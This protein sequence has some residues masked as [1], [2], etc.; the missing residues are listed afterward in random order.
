MKRLY[1]LIGILCLFAMSACAPLNPVIM[2]KHDSFDSYKYVYITPTG[3]VT[4]NAG[5]KYGTQDNNRP[6][7]QSINP[8]DFIA[9][10]L[11]KEGY[12]RL[13]ELSKDVLDRTLI[14]NY[15]ES[16]RHIQGLGYGSEVIIQFIAADTHEVVCSCS[17]EGQDKTEAEAIRVAITRCMDKVFDR[18]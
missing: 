16:D 2:T 18:Q 4:S 3:D 7:I 8:S 6:F 9:G 12:I 5:G 11:L 13:P 17:G 1:L 10:I 14:V 15:G